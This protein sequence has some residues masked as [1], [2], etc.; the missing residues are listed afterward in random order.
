MIFTGR[1][2][3]AASCAVAQADVRG[4]QSREGERGGTHESHVVPP[5]VVA[6]MATLVARAGSEAHAR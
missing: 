4:K 2:G 1:V 3:Y 6:A 5:A